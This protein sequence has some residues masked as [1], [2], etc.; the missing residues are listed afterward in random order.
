MAFRTFGGLL[1]E[2]LGATLH[3]RLDEGGEGALGLGP[4]RQGDPGRDE[5]EDDDG[6]VVMA[7][8]GVGVP[9]GEL[10]VRAA[11]DRHEDPLDLL[12]AA[13]LDDGDVARRVADDLVDRRREDGR[14]VVVAGARLA[15]PAE[16]DQVRLLLGGR[17]DDA[18]G[19]MST[20][21]HQRVDRGAGRGVVE[22]ALEESSSMARPGRAL[23]QGHPLG[24]LDDAKR[25][26]FAGP[27]VQDGRS[28]ADQFLRGR[29]VGDRDEDPRRERR[30]GVFTR[31]HPSR[32][33]VAR[34]TA[35][36]ARTHGPGAPRAPPPGS[37][38]TARFSTTKLPTRPK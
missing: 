33:S 23:R 11:A 36:A 31:C 9:D 21:P 22:D 19:G 38:V 5:V 6:C 35:S 18:L 14:A 3:V 12:G 20:D 25:G 7:S 28:D 30:P 17:L 29:G 4:D 27:G 2:R 16:D 32:S 26:Q 1:E 13:L 8:D 10:G 24:D 37:V 34:G 15:A